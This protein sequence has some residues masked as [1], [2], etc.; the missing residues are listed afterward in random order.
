M[1]KITCALLLTL[2]FSVN[3]PAAEEKA[4]V[5]P[6]D[7][8]VYATGIVSQVGGNEAKFNEYRDRQEGLSV[9]FDARYRQE[10]YHL[11]AEAADIG[12]DTQRYEVDG[13]KWGSYRIDAHFNELPHHLTN[14]AQSIYNGIGSNRLTYPTHPPTTNVNTWNTF[15]Y[16]TTRK[17]YGAGFKLDLLK[18]F[19]FSAKANQEQSRGVFP[20]GVAGFSPGNIAIEVPMPV[21]RTTNNFQMEAGY[22]GKPVFVSLSYFYSQFMDGNNNLYFR[23]PTNAVMAAQTDVYTIAPDN[24]S[25]KLDL[26]GAIRLPYQSSFNFNLSSS[27]SRSAANLSTSYLTNL[28][29]QPIA[30]TSSVFNGKV[31]NDNAA[32]VLKSSPLNFL[33]AQISFSSYNRKNKSD[34][35]TTTDP[36]L[37][38][39]VF[40]NTLFDDRKNRYGTELGFKLPMHFYLS[41]SLAYVDTH[42]SRIDSTRTRDNLYATELRWNGL[43]TLTAR[44]GYERLDRTGDIDRAVDAANPDTWVRRFDAASQ[45]KDTWKAG[46]DLTP[47]ADLNI[48]AGVKMSRASYTEAILGMDEQS[49]NELNLYVDYLLLKRVKLFGNYDYQRALLSQT[50]RQTSIPSNWTVTQ[51]NYNYAYGAGTE[52]YIVPKQWTLNLAYSRIKSDGSADFSYLSG[53]PAGR[54]Q[55]NVDI[56]NWDSY[57]LTS[58]VAKLT[59]QPMRELSVTVGYAHE[60]FDYSDAQYDEYLYTPL[61]GGTPNYLTGAYRDSSYRA[62]IGFIQMSYRF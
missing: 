37:V 30:L 35:I 29:V 2:I 6:L 20:V 9:G 15:D 43:D 13:G 53:L 27:T 55:D 21:D 12:Y 5:K 22:A 57:T 47:L 1:K 7:V 44:L 11:D 19:F 51:V 23:N 18:P 14:D 41:G 17:S 62:D 24:N 45:K 40:T 8:T 58:Y 52:V 26:K 56:G 34:R 49:D 32:F 54:T 42:R 38:P 10:G 39:A 31:Q 46:V 50:Q 61:S 3:A 33:D 48:S 16:S 25:S 59:Y 36:S 28:G 4:A 60:K